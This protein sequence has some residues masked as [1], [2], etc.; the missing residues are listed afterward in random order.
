MFRRYFSAA[1][2][3]ALMAVVPSPVFAQSGAAPVPGT[4]TPDTGTPG[5]EHIVVIGTT[6]LPGTGIDIDKV[7]GN[8]Q[9]LWSGDLARAGSPSVIAALG[10]Q[11]G[12]VNINDNMD[13]P[14]QPDILYRGF[15]ASPVLGTPQGLAVYQN[16]VRINEAFG[17]AVNWDLFPDIAIDRL[18]VVS[19]NPVYGLN[20]LGGAVILSMKNG[21]SYQGG[22]AELS[23]GSFGRR[24]A[25]AEY[26]DNWGEFGAY[27][28]ARVLDDDDW[29]EFSPSALRQL[30][31]DF[32][33]RSGKLSLDLSYTGADNRLLSG[34]ATPVQEL[35]INR[36]LI[37]TSP[38]NNFD[39]LNFLTLNGSYAATDTLS[40]Q[41]DVYYRAF[42]Q[43]VVNGNTTD[44]VGC[45]SG[46]DIGFM[47]QSDGM[48]PALTPNG[49]LIPDI[50]KGGTIP[51][52]EN[53][54]ESIHSIGEGG[55][56]Q[57]SS[58]APIDGHENNLSIGGSIDRATTGFESTTE[59]GTVNGALQIGFSG[60]FVDTPENTPFNA[61]PVNLGATNTY[62]GLYATDTFNITPELAV[63]A[64]GRYNL[65]QIDLQDRIGNDLSGQNR[66]S[67]FD[68]ALG[69][70]YKILPNL[71]AYAGYSET[72]RTPTA[73]E[74]ECANPKIPCLLPSS[75]ASDPPSLKQVVA[76]TYEAGLRGRVAVPELGE[77]R[78]SWNASLFRT[79]VDDDIY[80]V[81]TSLSTG[82]F[83]NIGST[84]RQGAELGAR[85]ADDQLSVYANYSFIDATFE[86][87]LTLNS[88]QNPFAN[89]AGN[90]FVKPGDQLPGIP[91]QRFKVG[92]DYHIVADW[93]VGV[94]L[95]LVGSEFYRGDESNQLSPIAGY[96][97]TN[98]HSTYQ[99]TP[100]VQLFGTI[101]NLFNA[102]YANFGVL[103]DPTG[104]GAPG[105]PAGAVT[106]GPGVDNRFQ[107]PAAPL[108]AY[109]GVRVK[110]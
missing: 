31:G 39:Q 101:D 9:T 50:S 87:P 16:G 26:G 78:V 38:Q 108:A 1:P 44:F 56:V 28:A 27:L 91:Q 20:A 77:G 52:G 105:I 40:I 8:P 110:F 58:T 81:A 107:S 33:I 95:T 43:S 96:A 83:E 15:E 65:A 49:A 17:D 25:T 102:Q 4:G 21:F 63:T 98:L 12:S 46:A 18:D 60:L 70:A 80:G 24:S 109:G 94:S 71:T 14:F 61:T 32:S 106:N 7:A 47:C 73:S 55:T 59:L 97:V 75:L 42:R 10:D 92:A 104:V 93:V 67:R 35:S 82:F 19:A 2:L 41:G 13:N 53:D 34:S 48:T 64:S 37:F 11:L 5:A 85:Y 57:A 51:I 29:R 3:L 88:P 100:T 72:N 68:P 84:R 69:A 79:D 89:A 23:G 45:T 90:I 36:E 76:H 22:D 6:P 30:Y 74:I 99:V 66:Y 54:F 86:S 62:Y 103:G